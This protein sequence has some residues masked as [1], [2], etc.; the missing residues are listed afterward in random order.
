MYEVECAD[1]E[2]YALSTNLIAENMFVKINKEGNRHVLMDEIT[3]H[4]F[5]ESAV[6]NQD[7]FV[8]TSSGNKRR[9]QTK[10]GVSLCV[11]WYDVNTAWADLKYL[12]E[13]YPVQL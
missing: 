6:K 13:S 10:K 1:G 5:D 7:A 3:D 9:R 8:T 4:R 12:K 2:N 11:K